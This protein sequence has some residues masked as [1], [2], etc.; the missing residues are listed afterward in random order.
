[1]YAPVS[2][3]PKHRFVKIV[4][5]LVTSRSTSSCPGA[6]QNHSILRRWRSSHAQAIHASALHWQCFPRPWPYMHRPK[7]GGRVLSLESM[8]RSSLP[9]S[10]RSLVDIS[11]HFE[12]KP[13]KLFVLRRSSCDCREMDTRASASFCSLCSRQFLSPK[14][15]GLHV[16]KSPA[17]PRCAP[18]DRRFLDASALASHRIGSRKHRQV[19]SRTSKSG[20]V[21]L[22]DKAKKR[23]NR[24]ALEHWQREKSR[25]DL[26]LKKFMF[27]GRKTCKETKKQ[28]QQTYVRRPIRSSKEVDL[29]KLCGHYFCTSYASFNTNMMIFD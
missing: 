19:H 25:N 17:H 5:F 21:K 2:L 14:A 9:H 18:C 20:S 3:I 7:S 24:A 26:I 6:N 15:R 28:W 11:F 8:A 4:S 27:V 23:M 12:L 16:A 10:G 1:M 22:C 13:K 29:S